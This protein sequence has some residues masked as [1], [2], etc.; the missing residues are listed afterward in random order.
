MGRRTVLACEQAGLRVGAVADE[1]GIA[2]LV[3]AVCRL[4]AGS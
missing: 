2:G 1:P 4:L 3:T